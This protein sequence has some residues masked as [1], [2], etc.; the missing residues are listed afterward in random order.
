MTTNQ[1]DSFDTSIFLKS[2]FTIDSDHTAIVECAASVTKG[3]KSEREKTVKLFYF[4]RD[5]IRYNLF[6]ISVFEEDFKASRILEWGKGYCVQKAVL[7]TA[8]SRA[9]GIP[10]RLAFAKIK[11]HRLPEPILKMTGTNVFPRHGYNQFYCDGEWISAAATFD[12]V[13]CEK[14]NLPTVEFEGTKDAMLPI[15]DLERNPYI[16]YLEKY[17]ATEDL[18]FQWLFEFISKRYGYDKRP[19]ITRQ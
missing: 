6:M 11:N 4:V 18:P 13:L 7:L 16:E 3:C 14:N 5:S 19:W 17:Q 12:K 2:T 8:L 10:C 1:A 15:H 9:A